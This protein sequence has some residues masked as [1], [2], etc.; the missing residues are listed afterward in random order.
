MPNAQTPQKLDAPQSP[1]AALTAFGETPFGDS[2]PL[3]V[4]RVSPDG[5]WLSVCQARRD[6]TGDGQATVRVGARGEL[7]G[8]DFARYLLTP[9]EELAHEGVLGADASGRFVLLMQQG[10]LVL[11]DSQRRTS[12]DLSA[13]GADSR[14][15]AESFAELRSAAFDPT[16]EHLLY[17]R[18]GDSGSRIVVRSLSDDTERMLDP[19]LGLI[20][21]ARF[22]PRSAFV[23][24]EMI[25]ADSNKNG[26]AD[27]PAPLLAAPRPCSAGPGRFHTWSER[28]DRLETVLVPLSGGAPVHE[29]DLIMPVRDGL[30]L[31]DESGALLF[32]KGGKKRVLEPAACK[33]HVVHADAERELFIVGCVQP[34]KTGRV[35]LDLI[36]P[37]T[38]KPLDLELASVEYDRELSDSPRLVALYPGA[39]TVLFDADK[40][41]LSR[42]QPGDSV[43]LTRGA[44]ALVRR[45]NGLVLYDADT[46]SERALIGT[47]DKYPKI[48]ISQPFAFVSPLLVDLDGSAVAGQTK[49]RALAL[50]NSGQLLTSDTDAEAS[51][52]TR[53]PVRWVQVSSG[54][55]SP[56]S[57][58]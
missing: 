55:A 12:L 1:P 14:L 41:D 44:H 27:F 2:G 38:R 50:S 31:R 18:N 3:L 9:G 57:Q 11:W 4:E 6:S 37:L 45:G 36:T 40:L 5:R 42:L 15:S 52:L 33:G 35:S 19:G 54:D 30:L 49:H 32:E 17:V 13:R 10:A 7:L 20:W 16:G 34:K 43:I 29:P 23:V 51:G 56:Q 25:T 39:D 53:G 24:A 48:L 58:R 22:A 8:H 21:R 47:L 46:R 28:G 26:K